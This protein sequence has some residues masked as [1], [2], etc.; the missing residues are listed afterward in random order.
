MRKRGLV[1]GLLVLAS[2][3]VSL[4]SEESAAAFVRAMLAQIPAV[5]APCGEVHEGA[6]PGTVL[7][8]GRV[9]SDFEAFKTAWDANVSKPDSMPALAKPLSDWVTG[10]GGRIRWYTLGDRW[11]VELCQPVV[12]GHRRRFDLDEDPIARRNRRCDAI[13]Q[14]VRAHDGG[15]APPK[16][17]WPI[18]T[19]TARLTVRSFT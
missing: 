19:W 14:R 10:V 12:H 2:T 4:A 9:T 3:G 6:G 13:G 11:L 5:E 18:L 8:C 1:A 7:V 17:F 16:C 15:A